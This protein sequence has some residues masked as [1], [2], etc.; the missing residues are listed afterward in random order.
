MTA[1]ELSSQNEYKIRQNRIYY[2]YTSRE[3]ISTN[4]DGESESRILLVTITNIKHP[5]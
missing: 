4:I 2:S 3:E 5:I 1:V